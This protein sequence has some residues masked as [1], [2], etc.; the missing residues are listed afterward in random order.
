MKDGSKRIFLIALGIYFI[1]L[2]IFA[3]ILSLYNNDPSQILYACY[4]GLILIGIGMLTKKSSIILSQVYLL[5][6]P[7]LIWDI[8]FFHWIIFKKPLWGIT[9]YFFSVHPSI[10]GNFV[11]LQH[12]YLVPLS[13][14]AL[15]LMNIKRRDAW[16]W[17]LLEL[18]LI[19]FAVFT[20][21]VPA[22]NVDCV[23]RPC[24]NINFGIPYPIVW[25]LI[26]FSM[27]GVTALIL[28]HFLCPKKFKKYQKKKRRNKQHKNIS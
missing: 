6:I 12:L 24:I 21:S 8:D 9:D 7:I 17:S 3:I 14:Y 1:L 22:L 18:V 16:K 20:L 28:N 11:S 4:V 27:I 25:F 5:T 19:F 10:I 15:T 26:S 2:G 13:V 23:F